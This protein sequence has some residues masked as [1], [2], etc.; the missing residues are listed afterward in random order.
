MDKEYPS[1]RFF[2]AALYP[3][4]NRA[5]EKNY[6][7]YLDSFHKVH[8]VDFKEKQDLFFNRC[9]GRNALE[10]VDVGGI[11]FYKIKGEELLN[12][13]FASITAVLSMSADHT[14]LDNWRARVGEENA[15]RTSRVSSS[16]G[17]QFHSLCENYLN[18]DYVFVNRKKPKEVYMPESIQMFKSVVPILNKIE[19]VH[20]TESRMLSH[21]LG[22]AGTTD[23]LGTYQ[24]RFSVIDFKNSKREKTLEQ[25]SDY[26]LQEAAYAVMAKETFGVSIKQLVTIIAVEGKKEPQVF[27]VDLTKQ[28]I[29][30]LVQ[31]VR[32]FKEYASI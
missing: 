17:E 24:G 7:Q 28:H 27:V 21:K 3:C 2:K 22:I 32:K 1:H 12:E 14:W 23:C 6:S 19:K 10:R 16:R 26:I 30:E 13:L 31:R 25:I 11:R 29:E 8:W 15:E 5:Y 9:T 4:E 18:G 20:G